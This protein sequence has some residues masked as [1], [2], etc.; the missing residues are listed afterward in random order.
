MRLEPSE[1]LEGHV[2]LVVCLAVHLPRMPPLVPHPSERR[3][4]REERRESHAERGRFF[5]APVSLLSPLTGPLAL[6]LQP[7]RE[8]PRLAHKV[9]RALPGHRQVPIPAVQ[10]LRPARRFVQRALGFDRVGG[11]IDGR[12][13]PV[14]HVVRVAVLVAPVVL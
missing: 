1:H 4:D 3:M 13:G 9:H 8:R 12:R 7:L 6:V 5:V 10:G 11:W 14:E 2:L